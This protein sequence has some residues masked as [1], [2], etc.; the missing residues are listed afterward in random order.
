MYTTRPLPLQLHPNP[1]HASNQNYPYQLR[2]PL[3]RQLAAANPAD[4][5]LALKLIQETPETPP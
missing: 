1:A 4:L 5:V 2:R 3:Q